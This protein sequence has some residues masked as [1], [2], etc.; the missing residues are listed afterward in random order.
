MIESSP[1]SVTLFTSPSSYLLGDYG[2]GVSV[3]KKSRF[4]DDFIP[5]VEWL[6]AITQDCLTHDSLVSLAEDMLNLDKSKYG[7]QSLNLISRGMSEAHER[8]SGS[9][10]PQ[11]ETATLDKIC[12]DIIALTTTAMPQY[13]HFDS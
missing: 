11:F 5:S 1:A 13:P 3:Q 6:L 2:T 8:I 10:L 9:L 7:D 4:Q 12:E